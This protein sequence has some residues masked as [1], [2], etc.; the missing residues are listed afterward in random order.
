MA[1]HVGNLDDAWGVQSPAG[2]DAQKGC[3]VECTGIG[4]ET[5]TAAATDATALLPM[6]NGGNVQRWHQD[7]G[8][9]DMQYHHHKIPFQNPGAW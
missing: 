4:E 6:D 3:P 5:M 9:Q 8:V 1:G 7:I 2:C